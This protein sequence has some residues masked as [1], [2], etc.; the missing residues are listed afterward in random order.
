MAKIVVKCYG[1]EEEYS[2]RKEAIK[3]YKECADWSDG[4]E[5]ERYL[6]VLLDLY[7]GKNYCTDG[8]DDYY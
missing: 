2:S 8:E 6:N 7:D 5:R 4:C 1:K 3:F